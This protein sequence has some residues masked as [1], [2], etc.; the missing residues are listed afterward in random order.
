M[1][2]TQRRSQLL[3]FWHRFGTMA[4]VLSL[5]ETLYGGQIS[6]QASRMKEKSY[7]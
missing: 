5:M 4:Q 1:K 7:T 6:V 3:A 2:A